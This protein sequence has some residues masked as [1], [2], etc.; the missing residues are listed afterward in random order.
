MQRP[1]PSCRHSA[2]AQRKISCSDEIRASA[3]YPRLL[4]LDHTRVESSPLTLLI[5]ALRGRCG[6]LGRERFPAFTETRLP[7]NI[8]S[9]VDHTT[10]VTLFGRSTKYKAKEISYI[11]GWRV[12]GARVQKAQKAFERSHALPGSSRHVG[13]KKNP[14]PSGRRRRPPPRQ[15]CKSPHHCANTHHCHDLRGQDKLPHH[16]ASPRKNILFVLFVAAVVAVAVVCKFAASRAALFVQR[17]HRR[18]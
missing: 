7:S 6:W 15:G 2:A 1:P 9:M 11:Y 10:V 17:R 16:R 3:P 4:H 14:L 13:A 5:G 12:R 8:V 18:R